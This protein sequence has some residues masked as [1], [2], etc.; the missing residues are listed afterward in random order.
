MFWALQLVFDF[1]SSI[2]YNEIMKAA[3][4]NPIKSLKNEWQSIK[5]DIET[6]LSEF[7]RLFKTASD[8]AIFGELAFC[9]FT[10]QSKAKHCWEAVQQLTEKGL[11]H[12]DNPE[13]IAAQINKVRF[14][15]NKARYVVAARKQFVTNGKLSIKPFLKSFDSVFSAREWLVKN[16]KGIGYKEAGHFLRNI[17]MGEDIAI[18]DRHI[19]KNLLRLGV[20]KEIPKTLTRNK[21]IEIEGKLRDF[22]KKVN[23]PMDHLDLLFWAREAGEIFK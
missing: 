23:I 9:L 3:A 12:H 22:S 8:D 6:R 1:T 20:I 21:Y 13:K 10:P 19:L 4:G 15:N 14:R 2:L 7:K 17:G 18:L 11:L 16:I 5:A